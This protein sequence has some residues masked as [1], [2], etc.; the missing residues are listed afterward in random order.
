MTTETPRTDDLLLHNW[1]TSATVCDNIT[2]F[3]REL[4]RETNELK[5]ACAVMRD[6]LTLFPS[7]IS[8]LPESADE[9]KDH[10]VP[11]PCWEE[12]CEAVNKTLSTTAGTDLLKELE[13][14]KE[15]ISLQR[16]ELNEL[17]KDKERLD[18][19]ESNNETTGLSWFQDTDDI[20]TAIDQ[21]RNK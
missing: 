19:V 1:G 13:G 4:E 17:R 8:N 11:L 7:A 5:A 18:W 14:F 15:T 9:V 3:A 21:A 16:E 2:N 12:W 20:R 10:W 6:A